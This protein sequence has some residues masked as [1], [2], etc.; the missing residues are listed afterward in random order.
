MICEVSEQTGDMSAKKR[1]WRHLYWENRQQMWFVA[2]GT[3]RK[4]VKCKFSGVYDV[5]VLR[6]QLEADRKKDNYSLLFY[7]GVHSGPV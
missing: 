1:G 6:G 4:E 7:L 2:S 3:N 5:V